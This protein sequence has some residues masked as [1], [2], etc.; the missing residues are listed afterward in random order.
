MAIEEDLALIIFEE[1]FKFLVMT[2]LGFP[3]KKFVCPPLVRYAWNYHLADT[4]EYELFCRKN[5]K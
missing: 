2:F 3:S 5:F 4:E 1:Y